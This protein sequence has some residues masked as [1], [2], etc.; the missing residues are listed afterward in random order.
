MATWSRVSAPL[1]PVGGRWHVTKVILRYLGLCLSCWGSA[2]RTRGLHVIGPIWQFFSW[3]Y[4][5]PLRLCR[6]NTLHVFRSLAA[7]SS[8]TFQMFSSCESDFS[9]Q[10]RPKSDSNG[11]LNARKVEDGTS[12]VFARKHTVGK[13]DTLPFRAAIGDPQAGLGR[14][15]YPPDLESRST[16]SFLGRA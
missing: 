11:A 16:T 3:G 5:P 2:V 13:V 9:P 15:S 7:P 6:E 1:T 8:L 4:F 10:I 14:S 12:S